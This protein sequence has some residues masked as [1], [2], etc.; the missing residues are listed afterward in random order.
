MSERKRV[1]VTGIGLL[2]ACGPGRQ[3]YWRHA[4]DGRS[5]LG[6]IPSLSTDDAPV[7]G[8]RIPEFNP[9]AAIKQKKAVK[10][11]SRDVQLAVAASELAVSDAGLDLQAL[12]RDAFGVALGT[13]GQI[14][15][16]L[17][18]LN[19]GIS[20]GMDE[21]GKFRLSK[22]AEEGIPAL[23]PLWF[24]KYIPNMAA[25]HIS[26]AHQ[27]RGPSNTVTTSSAASAH[28]IGEAAQVIA[29]G[30][31]LYMLGGGTDSE[32]NGM[33]VS[34]LAMLKLLSSRTSKD[35][36]PLYSPFDSGH[37]GLMPGEG[38]GIFVLEEYEQAKKRGARIYGELAGYGAS[39][40][41]GIF[42]S[43]VRDR[44]ARK[45]AMDL[46]LK[47]AGAEPADL[48]FII[49]HGSG[50]PEEDS[51]EAEALEEL[52]GP[53]KREVPVTA[54]KPIAGHIL[55]G[56]SAVE[57]AA[58]LASL[59][60]KVIPPLLN[61]QRPQSRCRLS[62]VTEPGKRNNGHM[63]LLNAFGMGGQD[64]ALVFKRTD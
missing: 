36:L 27:L 23:F 42:P 26:I 51:M 33:G 61:L 59:E 37:D 32:L 25:C 14:N 63:F 17:D 8:G 46:A 62:F 3:L 44:E 4:R 29:R 53:L 52:L 39:S 20:R 21:N 30:D 48:D 50:I 18:E 15:N 58:G 31:A 28:A 1:V 54:L 13:Q 22:F 40:S 45:R 34:R 10:L 64:A 57:A 6:L 43:G 35:G 12:D 41:F 19:Q 9:R 55:Y 11:M 16:E 49:A 7:Y 60:E 2:T 56:G 5:S 24:L 47:D 38:A